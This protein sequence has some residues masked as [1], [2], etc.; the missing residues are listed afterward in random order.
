[1]K[2]FSAGPKDLNTSRDQIRT[3]LTENSEISDNATFLSAITRPANY[4][5]A[6]HLFLPLKYRDLRRSR[7]LF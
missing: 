5:C 7:V 6:W 1:M 4:S 2:V 3:N